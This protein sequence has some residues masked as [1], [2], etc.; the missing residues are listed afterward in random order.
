MAVGADKI[1]YNKC[2]IP[3]GVTQ[4]LCAKQSPYEPP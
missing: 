3:L 2:S 4:R 1:T